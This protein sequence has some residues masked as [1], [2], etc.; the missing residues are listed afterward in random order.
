M[1]KIKRSKK[2]KK[3]PP[4]MMSEREEIDALGPVAAF[5]GGRIAWIR[6]RFAISDRHRRRSRMTDTDA[7]KERNFPT[8]EIAVP[9]PEDK[10]AK[11]YNNTRVLQSEAWRFNQLTGMQRDA[12]KEMLLA[13]TLRTAGT[14]AA[15]SKYGPVSIAGS[16]SPT[17]VGFEADVE[18]MWIE[19]TKEAKRRRISITVVI[20]VLAE[21]KTLRDIEHERRMRTGVPF[22][23]YLRALTLWC[24]LRGWLRPHATI[25]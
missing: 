9:D 11:R 7:L 8:V 5:P 12:A 1:P 4:T 18:G 23:H 15:V 19:W 24:E 14:A 6:E 21:P 16:S 17:D 25:S 2:L 13:I 10:K 3:P 22:A 20:E